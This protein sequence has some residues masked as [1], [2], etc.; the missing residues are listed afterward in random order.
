MIFI[1]YQQYSS[2]KN[3]L[4]LLLNL[5]LT[6]PLF[7]YFGTRG[8]GVLGFWGFG[9][10]AEGNSPRES[11]RH[12]MGGHRCL[13]GV[14]SEPEAGRNGARWFEGLDALSV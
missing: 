8:F 7:P 11:F 12:D 14:G 3:T 13:G 5:K 10:F 4:S 9:R 2:Q 1:L 6:L